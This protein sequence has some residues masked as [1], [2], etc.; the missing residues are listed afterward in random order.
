MAHMG[1]LDTKAHRSKGEERWVNVFNPK[2]K[3]S[4]LGRAYD[5]IN[6]LGDARMRAHPNQRNLHH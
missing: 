4:A 6:L 1:H 2:S 5:M 3:G